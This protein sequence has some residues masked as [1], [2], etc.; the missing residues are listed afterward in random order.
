MTTRRTIRKKLAL[1]LVI[2]LLVAEYSYGLGFTTEVKAGAIE[3]DRNIITSVSMAVYGPDGQTVTGD[4][5]EQGSEVTLNYTWVLQDGHGYQAGDTFSFQIPN[6]FKLYNDISGPLVSDEGDV[7]SFTVN[8]DTYLAVMTFNSFIENHDNVHGT[9]SL[10]TKFDKEVIKGSTVQ[11]ISF[12]LNGDTQVVVL[13]FKPDVASTI[14]KKGTPEGYNAQSIYWTVDVNK[15]LESVY[16]AEVTDPIPDGLSLDPVTVAVYQL[17]VGLDGTVSQGILVDPSNYTLDTQDG[18]LKLKFAD[19]PISGAYRIAFS[20][21]ITNLAKTKFKNT[22]FFSGDNLPQAEAS[23]TVEVKRA[24]S[25]QKYAIHYEPSIQTIT[26]GINYNYNYGSISQA[27]AVLKDLFNESQELVAGSVK[28]Y[29]VTVDGDGKATVGAQLAEGTDYTLTPASAANKIGFEIRFLQ[30]VSTPYFIEYKTKSKER[31]FSPKRITNTV[32]SGTYRAEANQDIYP[33]IIYKTVDAA[34]ANYRNKTADWKITIN[35]DGYPMSN[36]VVKD[37][38][39][40]SGLTFIPESLVVRSASGAV[41]PTS[42]YTLDYDK[43]VVQGKGFTVTFLK[44]ITGKYTISY[45]LQFDYYGLTEGKNKFY[46]TAYL[47]WD[48][49]SA[50]ATGV[51]NPR[52]EVKNNG[53][54][55]GEYNAASKTISWYVAANYNSKPL[56]SAEIVDVI[57]APQS[58]IDGSVKLKELYLYPSGLTSRNGDL[59]VKYTY[60][61]TQE[62]GNSILRIKLLEPVNYPFYVEF[63]TSL[64]GKLINSGKINNTANIYDDNKPV[65]ADLTGSVTIPFGGEYV[66]KNGAQA[67]D[68]INWSVYINRGQSFIRDAKITDVGSA[69]QLLLTDSFHLYPTTVSPSGTVTKAGPELVKGTDYT[70]D[71]TTTN[72]GKQT[73]VLSFKNPIGSAYILEYQSLIAARSGETVTNAVTLSGNNVV[74]VTKETSTEVIVGVSTGSGTGNGT[75]SM[76]TVK[77]LDD[78]DYLKLLAGA[79]FDLYRLNGSERLLIGTQTTGA[80]GVAVFNGILAGSYILVETKAPS[81]YVLDGAERPVTVGAGANIVLPITNHV[82]P[83]P[84]PSETPPPSATPTSSAT[85]SPVVS[86]SPVPSVTPSPVVSASPAPSATPSPAPSAEASAS[87]TPSATPSPAPSVTPSAEVSAAPS[88]TPTAPVSS[89]TPPVVVPVPSPSPTGSSVPGVI[90]PDEQIPAG[91]VNPGEPQPTPLPSVTPTEVPIDDEVPLGGVDIDDDDVPKGNPSDPE[92]SPA[93]GKLPKTGEGSS[94][95][96]YMGGLGLILIGIVINRWLNRSKKPE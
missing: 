46:N 8:K 52:I 88:A 49:G 3:N 82:A 76:L 62:N 25:L 50:S 54:K 63:K 22:A 14:E 27:D 73:F 39:P 7:G 53:F 58:L 56:K 30:D 1:W 94:L 6:Q 57:Q 95:P 51:F 26:W 10:R 83:S 2:L 21:D 84:V 71:V 34:G 36:V 81:G 79:T 89:E 67:G 90:I 86:A 32:T 55:F 64:D 11:Q 72:D 38:F 24:P 47:T 60:T 29:N 37:T 33:V 59:N 9:L 65:S 70:L 48:G 19:S 15:T 12:P 41:V 45:K 13:R 40:Y 92:V 87:P 5:Y 16:G 18:K 91:P 35:D 28:V 68:K 85:P 23:S 80:D 75:R 43:P 61:V 69:N 93:T 77:K 42:E 4:V 44:P 78:S 17:D 20:T 31:L 96:I 66:V 74:E